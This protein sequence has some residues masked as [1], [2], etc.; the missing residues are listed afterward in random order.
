M[1][2]LS[3]LSLQYPIPKSMS[4]AK[5]AIT[6]LASLSAALPARKRAQLFL[7]TMPCLVRICRA[8]PPLREETAEMLVCL[9]NLTYMQLS[10]DS[11]TVLSEFF[12]KIKSLLLLL[13]ILCFCYCC[14][15][16]CEFID[17][18]VV[19][20]EEVSHWHKY[21]TAG[22]RSIDEGKA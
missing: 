10:K 6:R 15:W 13:L 16:G 20:V 14:C 5:H 17:L 2:L 7:P 19:R 4:I 22:S 1:Q 3:H 9:G 11:T 18:V 8:F 21:A 12:L